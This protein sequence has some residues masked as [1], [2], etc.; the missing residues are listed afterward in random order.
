MSKSTASQ[1]P[2]GGL[3]GVNPWAP[4][5]VGIAALLA[6]LACSVSHSNWC[7]GINHSFWLGLPWTIILVGAGCLLCLPPVW[8]G[9]T[10]I[11]GLLAR[12][13]IVVRRHPL[14]DVVIA[15]L[16]AVGFWL[17]RT[18]LQFLGDGRL[19]TRLLDQGNWFRPTELLD[20]WIHHAV[21]EATRRIW[22]W[23]ASTVHAVLSVA[24]GFVFVLAALRLGAVLRHKLFAASALIS[25]GLVQLFLGYAEVYSLA[26]AAILVYMLLA[27][28]F[29]SG[30]RRLAWVGLSL[31]VGVALHNALLFLAPSFVY[32]MIA[33]TEKTSKQPRGRTLEGAAFLAATLA[34]AAFCYAAGHSKAGP[35]PLML[36]PIVSDPA[37]VEQSLREMLR[38]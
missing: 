20:R 3:P 9:L 34:L 21:L 4:A 11:S 30:R 24:A 31:L 22:N 5:A 35:R 16:A 33:R 7:W 17:L 23:D 10:R 12:S 14:N 13:G 25:L 32:L 38:R 28:E 36:L 18:R 2:A 26:T 27:V 15:G 19:I 29:V 8:A 6:H 37:V 1:A